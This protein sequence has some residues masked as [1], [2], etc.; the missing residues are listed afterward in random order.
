MLPALL[1]SFD[2]LDVY[3]L[4]TINSQYLRHF[5]SN[6]DFMGSGWPWFSE[7]TLMLYWQDFQLG[8]YVVKWQLAIDRGLPTFPMNN[9]AK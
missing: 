3:Q 9:F 4:A 2:K 8:P 7:N 5:F 1:Y 6:Y